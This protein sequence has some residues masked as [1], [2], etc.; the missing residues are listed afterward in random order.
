M[1]VVLR[2][3]W[4]LLGLAFPAP[5]YFGLFS[6]TTT[7]IMVGS[8]AAVSIIIEVLRFKS[9]VTARVFAATFRRLLRAEEYRTLNAT[10][11]YLVASFLA[12]L[13]LP[14]TIAWV[15]LVYLA[16]GDVAAQVVGTTLGHVRLRAGKTL[17][18][19][20][21]CLGI[22]FAVGCFFVDW[23]LALAGAAAAATAELLSR[24]WVDNLTIPIAAGAAM[25]LASAVAGISFPG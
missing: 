21:G 2:K 1:N 10:V 12:L 15:A 23:R 24:G 7:L 19:T 9:E 25:W 14:K 18:G 11:P 16:L 4:H 17:E 5:Y 3:G 6:K 20:L 13:I 22:C 8:A